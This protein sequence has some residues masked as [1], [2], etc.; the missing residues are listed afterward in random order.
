Q[1]NRGTSDSATPRNFRYFSFHYTLPHLFGSCFSGDC[2]TNKRR[3]SHRLI[4]NYHRLP[5]RYF[6]YALH[7]NGEAAQSRIFAQ[8]FASVSPTAV[9]LTPIQNTSATNITTNVY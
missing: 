6:V 5:N 9:S 1:N 8:F 4:E 2:A 7:E 3:V